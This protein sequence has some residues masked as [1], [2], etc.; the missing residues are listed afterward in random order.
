MGAVADPAKKA[1]DLAGVLVGSDLGRGAAVLD[2]HRGLVPDRER[3]AAVDRAGHHAHEKRDLADGEYHLAMDQPDRVHPALRHPRHRG[4]DLDAA[5]LTQ[6]TAAPAYR[7][8]RGPASPC[9]PVLRSR[10]AI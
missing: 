6:G 4:P 9:R 3:P 5:V 1:R 7:S 8:R 10:W 2:Q